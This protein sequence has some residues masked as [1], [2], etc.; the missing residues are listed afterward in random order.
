MHKHRDTVCTNT[1]N[2]TS[3]TATRLVLKTIRIWMLLTCGQVHNNVFHNAALNTLRWCGLVD[4][5][6]S[7][8]LET[9]SKDITLMEVHVASLDLW[10][11][12]QRI[13]TVAF[14]QMFHSTTQFAKS[15]PAFS[16]SISRIL[17]VGGMARKVYLTLAQLKMMLMDL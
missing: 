16:S 3:T 7:A 12:H 13:R 9:Q 8:Y 14:Y 15:N 17:E 10:T 6:T 5:I 2:S 4:G 1:K 11:A